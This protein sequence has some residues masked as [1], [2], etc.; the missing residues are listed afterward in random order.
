MFFCFSYKEGAKRIS[1]L[2]KTKPFQA[3]ERLLKFTEFAIANG[4]LKELKVEGRHL[5]FIV[6]HNLDIILPFS[7]AILL[8]LYSLF[9]F[10][11][12]LLS[13][14]RDKKSKRE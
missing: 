2:L 6:Y 10:A 7:I 14:K 12:S 1:Q 13:S 11:I 9:K 4:G 5:S 8:A 3:E